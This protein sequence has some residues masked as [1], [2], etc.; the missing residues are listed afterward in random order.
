MLC[1][2]TMFN[3]P[4]LS[5]INPMRQLHNYDV[6]DLACALQTLSAKRLMASLSCHAYFRLAASIT[7]TRA[8]CCAAELTWGFVVTPIWPA[9]LDCD[10]PDPD[11]A[12]ITCW[13]EECCAAALTLELF[14]APRWPATCC[15]F[16]F[17]AV[18]EQPAAAFFQ[19]RQRICLLLHDGRR[20]LP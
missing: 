17:E 3:F 13:R 10:L 2:Q 18:K 8:A 16:I 20:R 19:V 15:R 4:A 6:Y 11:A 5:F 1:N 14:A 7:E 12:A 9:M